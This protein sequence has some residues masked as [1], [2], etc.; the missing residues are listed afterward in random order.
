MTVKRP[1]TCRS[2][3][4]TDYND[5]MMPKMNGLDACMKIREFSKVPHHHAH[6]QSEDTDKSLA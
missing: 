4:T 2:E 6:R 3:N 1:S 5:L